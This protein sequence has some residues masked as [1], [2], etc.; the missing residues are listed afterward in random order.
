VLSGSVVCR[1]S[2]ADLLVESGLVTLEAAAAATTV[3]IWGGTVVHNS[4]GTLAT[5][6]ISGGMLDTGQSGVG[7]TITSLQLNR[8][9]HFRWDPTT[10]T[11]TGFAAPD[12]LV[13]LST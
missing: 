11:V 4:T 7:R 12:Q 13:T 9:A 8:G 6:E 5:V 10:V 2:V 3:T 1:A